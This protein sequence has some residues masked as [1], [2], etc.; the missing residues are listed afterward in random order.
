MEEIGVD[1]EVCRSFY[2]ASREKIR[3][4]STG[5]GVLQS[6][7][8]NSVDFVSTARMAPVTQLTGAE[9]LSYALNMKNQ[10]DS[11]NTNE[12]VKIIT[13]ATLVYLPGSFL[14]V[15]QGTLIEKLS[16]PLLTALLDNI[17]NELFLVRSQNR[18]PFC[19]W[20]LLDLRCNVDTP[21]NLDAGCL[22][23][24]SLVL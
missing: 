19:G 8:C 17:W 9:Q 18:K 5:F 7:V 15:C 24:C 10:N 13:V 4:F 11:A 12:T 3:G 20:G 14:G 23:D 1:S 16:S 22:R 2:A 21:H 6:R